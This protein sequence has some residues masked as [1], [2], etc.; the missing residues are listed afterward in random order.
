MA[1]KSNVLAKP[2]KLSKTDKAH[3]REIEGFG[4]DIHDEVELRAFNSYFHA[5]EKYVEAQAR[6]DALPDGDLTPDHHKV[7]AEQERWMRN[8]FMSFDGW[9]KMSR[10]KI[11]LPE[12]DVRQLIS[13]SVF[14][15]V[16]ALGL[17]E[18]T[19]LARRQAADAAAK[20]L[21]ALFKTT[22]V[23]VTEEDFGVP[24]FCQECRD[25]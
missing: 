18:H 22:G 10:N 1:R 24:P 16:D 19:G 23:M 8:M 12:A 9:Q 13:D 6:A 5:A 3:L 2:V 14:G 17:D 4:T 20:E 25:A 15:R 11:R 21:L 7:F